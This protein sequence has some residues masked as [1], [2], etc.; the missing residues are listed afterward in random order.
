M[1]PV[2]IGREFDSPELGEHDRRI[3]QL[4]AGHQD[5]AMCR[6]HLADCPCQR[7]SGAVSLPDPVDFVR[8]VVDGQNVAGEVLQ[9]SLLITG[10]VG[11]RA[12]VRWARARTYSRWAGSPLRLS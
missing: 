2:W 9:P 5:A 12:R 8:V 3:T 4:L 10:R 11:S 1:R 7:L 6:L